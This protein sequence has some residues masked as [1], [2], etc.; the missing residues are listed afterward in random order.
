M[1]ST[2]PGR[3]T[4]SARLADAQALGDLQALQAAGLRVARV[5]LTGGVAEGLSAL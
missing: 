1:T 4:A 3:A 5:R 2:C